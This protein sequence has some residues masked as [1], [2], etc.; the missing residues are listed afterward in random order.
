[1]M[2]IP[3]LIQSII[4]KHRSYGIDV[5]P[6]ATAADI[7][8]LEQAIGFTLP[9]DF[10]TMYS[11][12]NG[13]A[14]TEDMFNITPLH[15]ISIDSSDYGPNWF[16]FAEYDICSDLWGLRYLGNEQYEI[17]NYSYPAKPMTHSLVE[18]LEHF[19]AGNVFDKGGLYDWQIR[20]G[21]KII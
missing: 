18:F 1:M 21:L 5:H 16:Y 11:V 20:L 17:F 4:D 19:L 7:K 12:C 3:P 14:C 6:P 9:A 15:E 13:F 10:V 8:L 2:N